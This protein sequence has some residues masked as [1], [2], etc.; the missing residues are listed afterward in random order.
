M[1]TNPPAVRPQ[2]ELAVPE[3]EMQ[4]LLQQAEMYVRSGLLPACIDTP[5]KALAVAL[6]GRELGLPIQAALQN[7]YPI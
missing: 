2:Q 6:R 4:R 7:I 3:E 5:Q 1:S